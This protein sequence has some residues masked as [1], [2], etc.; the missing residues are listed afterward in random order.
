MAI[1]LSLPRISYFK[2]NILSQINQKV[3][4]QIYKDLSFIN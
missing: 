3:G 4:A 1:T 2:R